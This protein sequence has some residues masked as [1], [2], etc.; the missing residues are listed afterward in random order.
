MKDSNL[1]KYFN[2]IGK[3]YKANEYASFFLTSYLRKKMMG[4]IVNWKNKTVIDLMSGRAENVNHIKHVTEITTVDFSKEMNKIAKEKLNHINLIQIEND[5]FKV[6]FFKK[7]YDI[8]LCSFGIKTIKNENLKLFS[9]KINSILNQ[10]GEILLLEL[11]K[12]KNK[13][14]N[15][16]IQYYTSNFVPFIFGKKFKELTPF[17]QNHSNMDDLKKKLIELEI[18][19]I[20][21]KRY[22]DLFEIIHGNKK[23]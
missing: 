14:F 13:Y 7:K 16:F 5:F 15:T 1:E 12:P 23:L 22:F 2:S 6:N 10:N 17:I 21:H 9:E 20:E 3:K 18:N 4:K 19:I 8:I 11:V